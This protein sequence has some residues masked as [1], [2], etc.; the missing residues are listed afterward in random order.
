VEFVELLKGLTHFKKIVLTYSES[1][2][3][4]IQ[5]EFPATKTPAAGPGLPLCLKVS[6]NEFGGW[7]AVTVHVARRFPSA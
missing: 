4:L 7:H 3:A 2:V 6:E 1:G 5:E